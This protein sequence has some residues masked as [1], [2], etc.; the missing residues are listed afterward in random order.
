MRFLLISMFSFIISFSSLCKAC[1]PLTPA[2]IWGGATAVDC[3]VGGAILSA[4][5]AVTAKRLQGDDEFVPLHA[6]SAHDFASGSSGAFF[7]YFES[8][9]QS[10]FDVDDLNEWLYESLDTAEF[11][12]S[13]EFNFDGDLNEKKSGYTGTDVYAKLGPLD[14]VSC[15]QLLEDICVRDQ[16]RLGQIYHW[17]ELNDESVIY[18]NCISMQ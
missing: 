15:M 14:G 9:A 16:T 4:G 11:D 2:C 17:L 3:L 7:L 8:T 1:G 10:K 12:I 6:L 13:Q 5:A 18:C